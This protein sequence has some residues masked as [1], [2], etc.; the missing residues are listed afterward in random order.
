MFFFFLPL[1]LYF[2][3]MS[4]NVIARA[5]IFSGYHFHTVPVSFL[6]SC[7]LRCCSAWTL[8]HFAFKSYKQESVSPWR[9]AGDRSS[10]L[11]YQPIAVTG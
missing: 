10:S 9:T 11:L 4:D 6:V 2:L 7:I 3:T 8:S 5:I 1:S